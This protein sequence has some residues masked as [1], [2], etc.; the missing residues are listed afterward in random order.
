MSG[1]REERFRRIVLAVDPDTAE[2]AVQITLILARTWN[3]EI[4]A[5]FVEDSNLLRWASLPNPR[6]LGAY[7]GAVRSVTVAA[8]ERGLKTQAERARATLL[9]I[10]GE[11]S[12]SWKFRTLRGGVARELGA[13]LG[14]TD[15]LAL[16]RGRP[17]VA[18]GLGSTARS[19]LRMGAGPLLL[20]PRGFQGGGDVGALVRD[21]GQAKAIVDG[22]RALARA[23]DG[24]VLLL[25]EESGDG[26]SDHGAIELQGTE[27]PTLRLPPDASLEMLASKVRHG[28]ANT[29]VISAMDPLLS[30]G[31]LERFAALFGGAVLVIPTD[32]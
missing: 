1:E 13:L 11:E 4:E 22:A 30:P 25:Q 20:V 2:G 26:P 32:V 8:L 14:P 9:R 19:L 28:G 24:R 21:P 27:A 10:L 7:S 15:L 29:V 16:G 18:G 31:R 12:T 6:E 23:W 5:V 3:A 17:G